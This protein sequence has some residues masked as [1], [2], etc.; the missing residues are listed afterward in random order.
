VV[1]ANF[2]PALRPTGKDRVLLVRGPAQAV[3]RE[4][5]VHPGVFAQFVP[6]GT[7]RL[8][9]RQLEAPLPVGRAL[10]VV[11][12]TG[13]VAAPKVPGN[14]RL[15]PVDAV[16]RLS[17]PDFR[18]VIVPDPITLLFV[19]VEDRQVGLRGAKSLAVEH[20]PGQSLWRLD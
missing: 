13:A 11:D 2:P 4:G 17:V 9:V 16:G 12:E 10:P 5:D 20:G 1:A 3:G 19:V 14:A 15:D 7:V 18:I 6:P 8:P